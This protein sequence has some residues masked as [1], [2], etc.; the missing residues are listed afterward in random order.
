M[1]ICFCVQSPVNLKEADSCEEEDVDD[2]DSEAFI[3]GYIQPGE[4]LSGEIQRI[5]NLLS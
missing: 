4:V 2:D 5:L 1:Y 3:F